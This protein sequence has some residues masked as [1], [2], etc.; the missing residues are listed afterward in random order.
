MLTPNGEVNEKWTLVNPIIRSIKFGDLTYDS[1][2]AVEYQIEI[3]YDYA[4]YGEV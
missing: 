2:D 4:M 1:D 3:T